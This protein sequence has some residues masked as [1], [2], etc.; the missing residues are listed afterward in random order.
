MEQGSVTAYV[1]P[2][3]ESSGFALVQPG[4]ESEVWLG[5]LLVGAEGIPEL[6]EFRPQ[7]I[8]LQIVWHDPLRDLP[9]PLRPPG[10]PC[11]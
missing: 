4:Q 1:G 10:R 9:P 2:P 3:L 5:A 11:R 7:I 6:D 8:G